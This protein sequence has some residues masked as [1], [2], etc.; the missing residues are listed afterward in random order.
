[1]LFVVWQVAPLRF[2]KDLDLLGFGNPDPQNLREVFQAICRSVVEDDGVIFDAN[3][4]TAEA[5]REE[6]IYD[7]VRV[8]LRAAIGTMRV[9]VQVDVGFGDRV[10]PEPEKRIFPALIHGTGPTIRVYRPETS[11]AEKFQVIVSL[12]IANSRMK[13]YFDIWF[14]SRNFEIDSVNLTASIR[15]TFKRRETLIPAEIPIGLSD[16]FCNDAAKK[17]QWL[18]SFSARDIADRS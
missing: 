17:A 13:D 4:V 15:E 6:A 7:G 2:T 14:I 10:F 18:A 5:I 8:K 9:S 3:S 16:E 1:M 11:V 12:G